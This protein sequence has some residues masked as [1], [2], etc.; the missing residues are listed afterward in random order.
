MTVVGVG[1]YI[2]AAQESTTNAAVNT[3]IVRRIG[4]RSRSSRNRRL[5][6]DFILVEILLGLEWSPEQIMG[7]LK[8]HNRPCV[9]L[10]SVYQYI[11]AD[12]ENG[13]EFHQ[14]PTIEEAT[15]TTFHFANPHHSWERGTNENTNGL[16]RQY[17]P[18]G[19]SMASITQADC[20]SIAKRLE[21]PPEK[22][23]RLQN[24]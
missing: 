3:M 9:S 2:F 10:E 20:E 15:K 23:I 17:L 18:K 14:Y 8:R 22:T 13:T 12:K 1:K 6:P 24:T 5:T 11:W 7:Y 21:Q 19:T 16:I 4:W